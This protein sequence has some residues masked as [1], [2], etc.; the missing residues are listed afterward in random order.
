[1]S[2]FAKVNNGI[3]ETVIVA[4]QDF[5]NTFIDTSPGDW[6]ETFT[7]NGFA[8]IGHSYDLTKNVFIPPQPYPSWILNE[9][10]YLWESPVPMPW[11]GK[12]YNWNET[13]T[14]WDEV[15]D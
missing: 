12:K 15:T 8:G 13:T 5:F 1:M 4:D 11:D 2:H 7:D 10:I 14:S 6:I 9:D 3:V